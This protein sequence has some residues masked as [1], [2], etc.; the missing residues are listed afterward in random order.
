MS[1]LDALTRLVTHHKI[2]IDTTL[3]SQSISEEDKNCCALPIPTMTKLAEYFPAQIGHI[4]KYKKGVLTLTLQD[5]SFIYHKNENAPSHLCLLINAI[6]KNG[7]VTVI[8]NT[9]NKNRKEV[10][11]KHH[12]GEGY[13]ESS[14][15]LITLDGK[16]RSHDALIGTI[17]GVS[18]SIMKMYL[19]RILFE[20]ARKNEA[21]FECKTNTNILSPTTGKPIKVLYKPIFDISGKLDHEL[22]DKINKEGLSDVVLVRNEHKI[23]KVPDVHNQ[24]IPIESTLKILPNTDGQ[25]VVEWIKNVCRHF[26]EEQGYEFIK[27]KF[28]EDA[29]SMRQVSLRTDDIRL[30]ALEKTFIKKQ[31]Y[32]VFLRDL[33]TLMI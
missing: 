2:T 9:R 13:E 28:K 5:V 30:D 1:R 10:S 16:S 23:I 20:I 33:K 7:S 3:R 27:I 25:G 24:I 14:H 11:P 29:K 21:D 19:N 32:L 17:P 18:S 6:D 15:I 31:S 26:K 4:A 22:F 12:D 8:R